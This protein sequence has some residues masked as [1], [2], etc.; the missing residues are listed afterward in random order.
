MSRSSSLPTHERHEDNIA[1]VRP[2]RDTS[3]PASAKADAPASGQPLADLDALG[4]LAALDK[5]FAS[6]QPTDPTPAAK[7]EP[8][9]AKAPAPKKGPPQLRA[10]DRRILKTIAGVA[11]VAVA[12]WMPLQTLMQT[13]STE[14][15]INARLITLRAPIEGQ[16]AWVGNVAVGTELKPGAEV[17]SIVNPR[18][19]RG[20]LDSV[21]QLVGELEGEIKA[22]GGRRD[23]LQ[24]LHDEHTTN[25]E[26]FRAGRI[27]QLE[28]RMAETRSEISASTARHEEAQQALERA[29]ALADAGTGTVV[30]LERARR[31]ATVAA[32]SLE[33]L[34]H[35]RNTLDVEL[36]ALRRGVY[37]GDSYNDRPQSLQRADE[38]TLRLKEITADVAQREARLANLRTELAAENMRYA[39]RSAAG[40][41]APVSGSIWEVMTAPGE[42]VER[43]QDLVRLL[44]CSG[45]VVTATVGEAAYNK[46][47]VGEPARFRF[48][49]ESTDYEGRIVSLTGV[50]TA[51]ANLAIQPAALAKEPYRVT[52]S[53]PAMTTTGRCSVGRTGR[54]TF[55]S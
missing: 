5:A 45:L 7:P 43:G 25:A 15:I 21:A 32:Q 11:L 31:D 50:A 52:V 41:V 26:A 29:Q 4:R 16:I 30:A 20:R 53:L 28:S 9:T 33:A 18:A 42:S 39:Q 14:A 38:I 55:G 1:S 27:A 8:S 6:P 37:V 49:G 51:P 36:S 2:A 22:L 48:R 44:D 47:R 3:A 19:E 23:G 46:L 13:T 40:L 54:V 12:G 35:R 17:L 34:G 24:A 10:I